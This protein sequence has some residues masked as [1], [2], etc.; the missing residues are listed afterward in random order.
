MTLCYTVAVNVVKKFNYP[1]INRVEGPTGRHYDCGGTRP[2]PSVT[3]ILS[4]TKPLEDS[5]A[6]VEWRERVGDEEADRITN[7]ASDIGD[8]LHANLENYIFH[9][10]KPTGMM[11]TR[12][13]TDLIIRR[14]LCNVDEVWGCEA[15]LFS[16]DLYAGTADLVGL[17]RGDE[18]LMDFKNSR[19]DKKREWIGDYFLQVCAYAAAHNEQYG[20]HI[21]K[22]VIFM[23]CWSGKFLEF[24]IEGDEFDEC[25]GKWYDRLAEYYKKYGI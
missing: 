11:M 5:L 8:A 25:T 7:S 13:L 2:L 12:L 21:R 20:T 23:G 9:G 17:H 19:K 4:A 1:K 6:L 16:E 24:I 22:C 14:G 15:F 18:A 3:T 10:T